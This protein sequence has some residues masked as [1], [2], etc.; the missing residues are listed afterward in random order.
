MSKKIEHPE[1]RKLVFEKFAGHCAYC[2][3]KLGKGFHIDHLI[4]KRRYSYDKG[5]L[6]RG[7]DTVENFMPS[8][9][10]CN[11]CKSDLS[12]DDFRQRVSDR[13][14]RLKDYSS[15]YNIAIRFGLIKEVTSEVIFHFEKFELING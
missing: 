1:V 14:L 5:I 6:Q 4:P 9:H 8:C 13:V 11:S 12:L 7:S 2:G 3:C 15:E 10:S